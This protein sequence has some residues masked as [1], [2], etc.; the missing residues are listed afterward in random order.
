MAVQHVAFGHALGA[1]GAHKVFAQHFQHAAARDAGDQRDEHGGQRHG[2]QDHVIQEGAEAGGQAGVALHR[3]PVELDR[4]HQ[5][6]QIPHHE[7]RHRKRQHRHSQ[8]NA[9]DQAL[10]PPG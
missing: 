5:D 10:V 1:R 7:G 4:E 8:G 6:Q 9:V 3:Q 2:G